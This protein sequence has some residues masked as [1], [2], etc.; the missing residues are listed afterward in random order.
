M[1]SENR[2]RINGELIEFAVAI[3]VYSLLYCR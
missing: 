2:I 1:D 3:G